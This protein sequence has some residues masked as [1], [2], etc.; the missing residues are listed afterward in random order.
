MVSYTDTA[1]GTVTFTVLV[2]GRGERR[3][4][5][6]VARRKHRRKHGRPCNRY[7]ALGTFRHSD[8]A[9]TNTFWFTGRVHG[10]R[11]HAGS[12]LLAARASYPGGV[13]SVPAKAGFRVR[14]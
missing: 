1:A 4:K 6:C 14:G 10:R 8:R 9:G 5:A 12:Y 3:G 13:R 11:L 2:P 7:R